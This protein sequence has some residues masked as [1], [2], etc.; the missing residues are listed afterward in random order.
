MTKKIEQNNTWG[1]TSLI[2]GILSLLLV[3]MPYFGLPLGIMAVV[4]SSQ[5]NK[6]YSTGSSKAGNVLGIIGIIVNCI[7]GLLALLALSMMSMFV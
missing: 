2:T 4:G 6:L 7:M 1:N 3:L 5:Q